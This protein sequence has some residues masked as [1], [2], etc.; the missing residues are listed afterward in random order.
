MIWFCAAM[1]WTIRDFFQLLQ[2]WILISLLGG[3]RG[4]LIDKE[5]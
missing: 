3:G 1:C 4:L 2:N 5:I